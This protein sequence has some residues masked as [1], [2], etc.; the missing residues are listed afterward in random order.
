MAFLS[1][2]LHP[3][4]RARRPRHFND[5]P[6]M[7]LNLKPPP[8]VGNIMLTTLV[9][10]M[11]LLMT[12]GSVIYIHRGN[13][14]ADTQRF[15]VMKEKLHDEIVRRVKVYRYG[16]MGTRSVFAASE[17]VNR[18]EFRRIVEAREMSEEFPAATG[19]GYI[20]RV[21]FDALDTYLEDA[22]ADGWPE[23][24]VRMLADQ[25]E[26]DDLFI[27]CY[28]EP[29]EKNLA[30]IGLDI[31]QESR[32]RAAAERAMRTGEVSMTEQITLVQATGGGPGFLILLPHYT[33]GLP[34]DTQAQR[35]EALEGWAYMTILAER[36]FAGA[37]SFID[38]ELDFKVFDSS[39][40]SL[41]RV[42]YDEGG[43]LDETLQKDVLH[44]FDH[45]R[46]RDFVPI[47]IGGRKW[48][49][50]MH[51]TPQFKAASTVGIWVTGAVGFVL[52]GLLALL[53]H[54]Q[55]TSL[56]R[57]QKIAQ[58]MTINL[59]E[60]ALTDRLTGLPNRAAILEKVQDAIHRARR[61]DGYH[62]AVLFLD[63]DR[64]KIINDS[65]GHSVGDDLL[66]EISRRLTETL[67]PHDTAG[68]GKDLST[69]AR[70]GG[71]EFIVLL[72]GLTQPED[73]TLVA[74]RLLNILSERY[75]LGAREVG[76]T[77]SIGV[78]VGHPGYKTAE[79]LIRDA[80][81]A[82]Y[83][84]KKAGRG[85]YTLFDSEMRVRA[86]ERLEIENDLHLALADQQF[87]LVYQPILALETGRVESCEALVRWN[88]P[89]HG[90]IGPDRFIPIA[91][92]TG[93]IIP[94]GQWVLDE[95]LR[96]FAEWRE[97]RQVPAACCISVN[98][99]R[100]QLILPDLFTAVTESLRR[101]GVPASL[102]H[103]EVTESQIMQDRRL[104]T[105]NLQKLRRTGVRIDIDDF[106]TGHS[107]LACIH[108]FPIDV[109]KID[110]SFMANL[111]TDPNLITV[112]RTVTELA[113]NLGVQVVAEGIETKAQLELLR[114][115][116]CEFAQGYLFSRPLPA[117]EIAAF[118]ARDRFDTFRSAA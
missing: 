46:F 36:M 29:A 106:G 52:T 12:I 97:K 8:K 93:L 30:A 109:L 98:L 83:E 5:R 4:S 108:E 110:R 62:Y 70:L 66:V 58:S 18:A 42:L 107:S 3:S 94:L 57:A 56:D 99:S 14:A 44:A 74:Q 84:A 114:S 100:K 40:L 31:G 111:E 72:D 10:L 75:Q 92:E 54:T 7:A 96:Q 89:K 117:D 60:A 59:R 35:E 73:A 50:A 24:H 6:L 49:V 22:Q 80:D 67:R 27:I 63:F 38:D 115:L 85:Q 39:E 95:A 113:R 87:S 105:A 103:L 17:Q 23:F 9:T 15:E 45:N 16:L 118:C 77:A 78:V 13:I 82:M 37:Q 33:P 116:S 86:K 48:V 90:L 76:S 25:I 65:L 43:H 19:I 20:H 41:E 101:H 1:K 104:A 81:T 102:L 11:S 61:V 71:D 47:E 21:A 55:S 79:Q 69:A 112:L 91:E 53:L 2:S 28:I 64:F 88:H 34:V 51:S 32:R 26:H 68:L